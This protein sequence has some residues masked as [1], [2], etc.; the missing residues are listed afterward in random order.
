MSTFI[1]VLDIPQAYVIGE[2]NRYGLVPSYHTA[3]LCA[4]LEHT[5]TSSDYKGLH[6]KRF[7]KPALWH[8]RS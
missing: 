4:H 5:K 3:G 6:R 1:P 7:G 2:A 8:L